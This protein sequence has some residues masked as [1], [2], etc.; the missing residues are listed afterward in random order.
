MAEIYS[1]LQDE[2]RRGLSC[3]LV[4]VI[5]TKGSTPR[6]KGAKMLIRHDGSLH[7]TVGGGKFESL[8]IEAASDALKSGELETRHFPLHELSDESF[9][10][11]CGGEITVLLE[12]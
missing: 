11:I 6:K 8:V 9:G 5:A 3:V 7:G 12:S 4:T 10:A 1:A 2:L